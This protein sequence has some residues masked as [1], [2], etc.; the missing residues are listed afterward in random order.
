LE[1]R[2]DVEV[3]RKLGEI[4]ATWH[5][6]TF[7]SGGPGGSD[8]IRERFNDLEAFDQLRVDPYYRT[9][10]VRMPE[11]ASEIDQYVSAMSLNRSA[12]VHGDFSPKN[13]LVG[14]AVSTVRHVWVIDFEVAHYGDPAFDLAFMLNHLMLKAIHQPAYSYQE[15]AEEF[16]DSYRGLI[17]E[18]RLDVGYVIGH[19]AC[20][21]LARVVGKSPAE[22]LTDDGRTHAL[23]I[24][25]RMLRDPPKSL[26]EAWS[27]ISDVAGR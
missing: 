22:Y 10:M 5:S 24:G 7:G 14:P 17:G 12:L 4:L 11:L 8:E 6:R 23:A 25:T 21:M 27:Y 9:T 1:G 20:L 18:D 15:C 26:S 16:L 3:A 13:V 2:V 19:V